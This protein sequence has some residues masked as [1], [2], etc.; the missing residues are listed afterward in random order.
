MRLYFKEK[1]SKI[2]TDYDSKRSFLDVSVWS[3]YK[4]VLLSNLLIYGIVLGT[5]F[6]IGILL[7]LF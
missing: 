5:L 6:S 3:F 4:C 7:G 2:E 1:E